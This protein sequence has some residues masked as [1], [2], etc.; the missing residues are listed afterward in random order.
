[1]EGRHEPSCG[2]FSWAREQER[3]LWAVRVR[4]AVIAGFA[5]LA[6]AL[7]H[8]GLFPDLHALILAGAIGC[9]CNAVNHACVRQQR[10]VVAVTALALLLDNVLITYMAARTGG[11]Q[12]PMVVMFSI[13]VVATAMLV[14]ARTALFSAFAA[15]AGAGVLVFLEGRGLTAPA[16]LY[17]SALAADPAGAVRRGALAWSAFLAYGLTLLVFVGGFLSERLRRREGELAEQNRALA[18]SVTSLAAA[19]D[20][21]AQAYTRLQQAE[22][23]MLHTEKMRALGQLVAGVAH[24]LNNPVSFVSS[25]VESLRQAFRQLADFI[26]AAAGP[27]GTA[28]VLE[29]RRGSL[30]EVFDE[31]AS[32][33]DDCEHGARR[34]KDIVAE[35]RSFSRQGTETSFEEVDV[36]ECLRR[37]LR[38]LRHRFRESVH[39]ETNFA[40]LPAVSG[41]ATQ[42]EQVFVN[43]VANAVEAVGGAGSIQV[44]SVHDM[45]AGVVRVIVCDNG[46]GIAYENLARV[47]EPFFTTKPVGQGTGVGLSLSYAIVR[48]HGGDV[49]V[50]SAPGEGASFEVVLPAAKELNRRRE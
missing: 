13:Q 40:I 32:V 19:R 5:S 43:L 36:N 14:T 45:A 7:R 10:G 38:M 28:E 42:L 4:W 15:A 41:L 18:A 24:E 50:A 49:S 9:A 26:A 48:R 6:L 16:L 8:F 31:V 22:A 44:R 12:S 2:R 3:L 30:A 11:F 33:L 39:L 25:N 46:P 34:I 23:Q 29:A 20:E 1:M 47:F 27:N 35:L 17:D 37:A 21:L